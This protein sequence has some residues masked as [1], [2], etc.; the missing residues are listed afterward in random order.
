[1]DLVGEA[2][3]PQVVTERWLWSEEPSEVE[4]EVS[5][6]ELELELELED[7]EEEEESLTWEEAEDEDV[8]DPCLLRQFMA[9]DANIVV[10]RCAYGYQG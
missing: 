9:M 5:E 7:D 6:S 1:M 4:L 8:K 3:V 2:V 10:S